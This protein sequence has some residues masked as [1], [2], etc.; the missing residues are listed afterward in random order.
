M[1][2]TN[3]DGLLHWITPTVLA[4]TDATIRDRFRMRLVSAIRMRGNGHKDIIWRLPIFKKLE[5]YHNAECYRFAL[6]IHPDYV[7]LFTLLLSRL[8][9]NQF[10][11][12]PAFRCSR[13]SISSMH[14][15][16]AIRNYSRFWEN[17]RWGNCLS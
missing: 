7:E 16:Q 5:A 2:A 1:H 14:H 13:L 3:L 6:Q 12:S 11:R 15:P 17:L 4:E 9:L 10:A 8:D